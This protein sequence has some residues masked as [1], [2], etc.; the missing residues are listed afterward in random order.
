V[1]VSYKGKPLSTTAITNVSWEWGDGTTTITNPLGQRT[2]TQPGTYRIAVVV[3]ANTDDGSL[4][5][6]AATSVTIS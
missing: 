2:Y 4:A 1:A 5:A 6:G 3:T